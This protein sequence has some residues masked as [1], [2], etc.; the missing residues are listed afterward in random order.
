MCGINLIVSGKSFDIQTLLPKMMETTSFRGPDASEVFYHAWDSGH[1]ALG[2]NRL[3]ITDNDPNADQPFISGCGNYILAFNGEIYNYQDLKSE[4]I[5]MGQ[6]FITASDTEVLL[7]WLRNMGTAGLG[8][9]KGMFALVFTDLKNKSILVARDAHGI[10][11]LFYSAGNNNL[12]VSSSMRAITSTGLVENQLNRQAV[13]EYLAYRHVLGNK[14]FYTQ[15]QSVAPG[16]YLEYHMDKLQKGAISA[17][18]T[19][20]SQANTDLRATIIDAVT[21]TTT[22]SQQAGLFLSGGVD[23]TLLLAVYR[24]ELGYHGMPTFTLNTGEDA[25]WAAKAARQFDANHTSVEVSMEDLNDAFDLIDNLDQPVADHGA[26]ATWLISKKASANHRVMLSGAGADELYAG[27]NRHR[28]FNSYYRNKKY[29]LLY[30]KYASTLGYFGHPENQKNYLEAIVEEEQKTFENFLSIYGIIDNSQLKKEATHIYN[31]DFDLREALDFDKHNYLVNDVLA[32][33]DLATMSHAIEGRVP[34]LYDDIVSLSQQFPVEEKLK[35]RG[36]APLKILLSEYGGK[37]Y[38]RRNKM[39]F[40]L[41]MAEFMKSRQFPLWDILQ[42]GDPVY[43][44]VDEDEVSR[45]R[46]EHQAGKK[47]WNMQLWSILVL[48]QWLKANNF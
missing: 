47:D 6:E 48:S 16:T 32:I 4:L 28:A 26:L 30:K 15:V 37:A 39:G 17:G 10:K 42:P 27:Y 21:L 41:P 3:R 11:P 18:S 29:W 33:T 35:L 25:V 34:Y 1:L 19:T 24:Q 45:M 9:L 36:K 22:V 8:E 13:N 43:E 31:P 14:T 5:G 38:T 23:S 2:A 20:K 40:G 46:S 7:Y 44:F 12:V